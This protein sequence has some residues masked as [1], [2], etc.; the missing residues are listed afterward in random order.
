M[1]QPEPA[2]AD[3]VAG[4]LST[5]LAALAARVEASNRPGDLD[6]LFARHVLHDVD[7]PITWNVHPSGGDRHPG[8]GDR[9]R[10]APQLAAAGYALHHAGRH[11]DDVTRSQLVAGL[12]EL[13]RRDPFPVD[14][15]TFAHD[16]RQLLGITLAAGCVRDDLPHLHGWLAQLVDDPRLRTGA[17]HLELVRLHVKGL[18]AD[19]PAPLPD[20]AGRD[21]T[22]LATMYWMLATGTGRPTDTPA[23]FAELER[24]IL[25]ETL[26]TDSAGLP[27][28]GTALLLSAATRI[29]TASIDATVLRRSHI[30]TV[31]R[32]F[33]AAMKRWRW[34]DPA[35]VKQ[36][37]RW[38]VTAEREV[39][40]IVWMMLR[41]VFDD[42]VDEEPLRRVGHSSY[43]CDFGLPRLGVL[44][45]I[46]YAR[47]TDD[48][49]KIEKEIMQDSIGYLHERA[50]YTK[51]VVF[52]YDASC[53]VQEHDV[54]RAAL[55]GLPDVI[56]VVIVSRPSQLPAAAVPAEAKPQG[57]T[58]R[59]APTPS[60]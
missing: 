10:H 15:V 37:I 25:A 5:Q 35:E 30:G 50:T 13:M 33:P 3:L 8:D 28:T 17:P 38:P 29:M 31:L 2:A 4:Q 26:R 14:G 19:E 49:K 27:V 11:S 42:L 45:E 1:T 21:V 52:I 58:R 6:G 55:L 51:L 44:V 24:R 46:K 7:I 9:L 56:D 18:L 43:R 12:V 41:S 47:S 34:D 22:E 59:S 54:T 39:Q 48:F 40:D 57:R 32:R 23:T 53:S 60:A 16:P 20:I 36:P